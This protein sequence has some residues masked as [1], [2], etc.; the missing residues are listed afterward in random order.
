MPTLVEALQRN[1]AQLPKNKR[2]T[3]AV[4][5]HL[6]TH[7]A[8]RGY[9]AED[10]TEAVDGA[11]CSDVHV[12]AGGIGASL[13]TQRR[14]FSCI[15]RLRG[16]RSTVQSLLASSTSNVRLAGQR[17]FPRNDAAQ[18]FKACAHR[19]GEVSF[20]IPIHAVTHVLLLKVRV[21]R[22]GGS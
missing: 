18:E 7:A 14:P 13:R 12:V 10:A 1:A 20:V 6:G 19:D 2:Q 16:A 11:T 22:F 4:L 8:Q 15:V 21:P 5:T 17:D 3:L 9:L